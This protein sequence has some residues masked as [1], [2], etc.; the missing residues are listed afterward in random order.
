MKRGLHF[1]VQVSRDEGG[2]HGEHLVRPAKVYRSV[3]PNQPLAAEGVM[4]GGGGGG[5]GRR[6]VSSDSD[7]SS[8][9]NSSCNSDGNPVVTFPDTD[10]A[11]AFTEEGKCRV[12]LWPR[13]STQCY[14]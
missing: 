5:G 3:H 9:M 2:D 12:C 13:G 8:C 7:G 10:M 1:D 4:I 6:N 14:H 11:V